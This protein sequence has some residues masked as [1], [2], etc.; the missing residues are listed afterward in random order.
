MEDND[1]SRI[2]C[3]ITGKKYNRLTVIGP[4]H[5]DKWGKIVWKCIC[6]CQ[7]CLPENE[8]KYS[9]VTKSNLDRGLDPNK[10]GGIKSCGCLHDE[11]AAERGRNTRKPNQYDLTSNEYGV[12]YCNTVDYYFLFDKEDYELIHQYTWH[13]HQD[14]YLRTCYDHYQDKNGKWHN[15][16]I[17]MHQLIWK[18]YHN[19]EYIEVDHINGNPFDNRKENFREV[20]RAQNTQNTKLYSSNTSGHKGVCWAK[21]ENRWKAYITK[22][23]QRINLGTFDKY[24]DAV[25][26]REEAE[27]LYFGQYNREE[28]KNAV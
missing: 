16:Y 4:D 1:W 28:I 2:Q 6:D 19:G 21:N 10:R 24:E 25:S 11:L 27:K 18:H 17:M 9:Y 22:E 20:T 23:H 5:R 8:R 3:D 13:R 7:V 26:A 12:G 15:K 14:G